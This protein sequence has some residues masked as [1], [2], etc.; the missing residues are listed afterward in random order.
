[1]D[2]CDIFLDL[3]KIVQASDLL[4]FLNQFCF[5]SIFWKL[6]YLNF[7]TFCA[8]WLT[9]S[10][11]AQLGSRG[12]CRSERSLCLSVS[13]WGWLGSGRWF[14]LEV[15]FNSWFLFWCAFDVFIFFY[16]AKK[17]EFRIFV[18]EVY[19]F[20]CSLFWFFLQWTDSPH[21]SECC[22]LVRVVTFWF[23]CGV[24]KPCSI[25]FGMQLSDWKF[26]RHPN[27]RGFASSVF[28]V[29]FLLLF[30]KFSEIP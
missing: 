12:T 19:V 27:C 1:M 11:L 18:F 7:C 29:F 24:F 2:L 26:C 10:C 5:S 28:Y 22:F 17:I 3:L 30:S 4:L 16:K 15:S 20:K 21:V 13:K 9:V 14:W 8:I 25:F 23:C 6:S